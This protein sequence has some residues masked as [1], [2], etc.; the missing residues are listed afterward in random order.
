MN[1]LVTGDK[2]LLELQDPPITILDPRGFWDQAR[3]HRLHAKMGSLAATPPES[4]V[5]TDSFFV[6]PRGRL[7]RL[8]K[9]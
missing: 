7:K 9:S 2:D 4:L 8:K 3:R 5:Q 1:A 6:V